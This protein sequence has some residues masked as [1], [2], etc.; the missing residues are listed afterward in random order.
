M[1]M[2]FLQVGLYGVV[3]GSIL[4]LGAIGVSL[5]YGILRFAHF[6]HGDLMALG[7]YF[8][9]SLVVGLGFPVWASAPFAIVAA[10]L[11]AIAIDQ[12]VY[13]RL[14][15]VEPVI[16]LISSFGIAIAL[17]SIIQLVW[18][19]HNQVY[20]KGIQMPWRV[21]D[22]IVKPDHVWIVLGAVV[23]VIAL[24]LFLT[25][26]K[27]GK[28]MRAMSDNMDLALVSGIPAE[29]VIMATWAVGGGLAAVAGIFLAMDTRLHPV[30]GW[31]V[32]LPVFAAAILGGIGRPYGAIAGGM[33]IGMAMELSTMIIDPTYKPAVAFGLMVLMLIVRPQGLF[34]GN[35]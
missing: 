30:M 18:G 34:K 27:T 24:H 7:A 22:L 4:T 8:A 13:R 6:A 16:L 29:R 33:V 20:V 25:R 2:D 26:T 5:I 31:S 21:G 1:L 10:A 32:L 15:R 28:A 12:I 3:L 35:A 9:L 17:R 19:P 23:L 14:R 11:A